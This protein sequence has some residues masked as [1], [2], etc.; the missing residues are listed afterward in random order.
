MA[1]STVVVSVLADTAKFRSGMSDAGR[2]A[3]GLGKALKGVGIG[4][5]A[6][7]IGA[8][9]GIAKLGTEAVKSL[10]RIE[11]LNAQTTAVVKSTGGAAGRSLKQINDLNGSLERLTGVEAESIQEGQNV[12]LTFTNI[13][14]NQFDAATKSALDLSVAMGTDVKSASM[15]LGKAL[16][17]PTAGLTKLTKQG[18]TFTDQQK[19]QV[20]AMQQA[21]DVAGAQGLILGELQKEF[22]GS[23]EAFGSTTS[24]LVAKIG[25]EFG[26]VTESL[27]SGL[28]PSI[29]GALT[30]VNN[31]LVKLN[32]S[33][34][35]AS[36]VSGLN[37]VIST[38]ITGTFPAANIVKS[39][40]GVA[41]SVSPLAAVFRYLG[42]NI[43]TVGPIFAQLG[44]ALGGAF[45]A[46]LPTVVQLA[47]T[48]GSVL[49]TVVAAVMPIVIQLIGQFASTLTSLLPAITA[50]ATTLGTALGT[51]LQ[52][53]APVIGQ[54]VAALGPVLTSILS[55]LSPIITLLA[56]TFSTL[57]T[58]LM[59]I[60]TQA[61]LPLVTAVL[62]LITP[63]LSLIGPILTPLI[64]LF[65]VLLTPI[66]G[67][68]KVLVS[69]LVPVLTILVK[70]ISVVIAIIAAGLTAAI[71]GISALFNG[72]FASA[73]SRIG[74]LWSS[75]WNGVR[76]VFTFQVNAVRAGVSALVGFF[77][78]VWGS[79]VSG[80]RGL[81][82]SIG[83]ALGDVVS[84][85]SGLP[86]R[87]LSALG[88]LGSL[89]FGSGKALVQGLING[90]SNMVGAA[91][92]AIS[93][94]M[95][96]ISSFLPHSPAKDG[97]FSGK[98]WTLYSGRAIGDALATGMTQ[99]TATIRNAARSLVG[100][101]SLDGLTDSD[102]GLGAMTTSGTLRS[103][104]TYHVTVQTLNPTAETG[105]VIAQSLDDW[106]RVN[107]RRAA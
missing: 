91:G 93:G 48:F 107:G 11:R 57:L 23:A 14:G 13:K 1:G 37:G 6:I 74:S 40:V 19:A 55:A 47:K 98:G 8:A 79:I 43:K 90:I 102:V 73:I 59:P 29:K 106:D 92:N 7:G 50:V 25:N 16:N 62:Q 72:G 24:G 61:I 58:A 89:F 96:K 53:L 99:R 4:A 81:G 39:F 36:F 26:T 82:S 60:I 27:A 103:G 31:F 56:T 85:V 63:L 20:A 10:A 38:L 71:K 51:V 54:L 41:S 95:S 66:L 12:L 33:K 76:A 35:F 49:T 86:G 3:G 22:G 42:D 77:S 21:G 44:A 97:P 18:V 105:R 52:T 88:N 64:Q 104:N 46:I 78:G 94:V 75:V 32:D 45:L 87:L 100:A 69:L 34:G 17:D 28:M 30:L 84:T 83:S 67:L 2:Q 70:A 9:V 68:V 80:V 5:A 15:T 101:A 65:T